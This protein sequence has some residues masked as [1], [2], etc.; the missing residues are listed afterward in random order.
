MPRA[1]H[2]ASRL[3]SEPEWVQQLLTLPEPSRILEVVAGRARAESGITAR[4]LGALL[5]VRDEVI[6]KHAQNKEI[7]R[8]DSEALK[9]SE[10]SALG[11]VAGYLPRILNWKSVADF[12]QELGIHRNHVESIV[13]Q[14]EKKEALR[15]SLD[16]KLYISPAGEQFVLEKKQFLDSLEVHESLADFGRRLRVKLNHLTAFFS[17]RGIALDAD[18]HGRARLTNEQ[19]EM[20]VTWRDTVLERRKHDDMI[21]DGQ[22][23]RSI[24][25]LAEDKAK[26]FAPQGTSRYNKIKGRELGSFRHYARAG[27]FQNKTDRGTYIPE[28]KAIV[29]FSSVTIAE[30]ARLV[31]VPVT[32]LKRWTRHNPSLLAPPLSGRRS[33][34][35]SI[36]ILL[37]HARHAY[38][39]EPVLAASDTIPTILASSAISRVGQEMGASFSR[40]CR[41]LPLPE[42]SEA[43]LRPRVG[44]IPRALSH[45]VTSLLHG[46]PLELDTRVLSPGVV[47]A[48]TANANRINLSS[49]ELLALALS[50]AVAKTCTGLPLEISAPLYLNV[51]RLGS[52]SSANFEKQLVVPAGHLAEIVSEWSDR[53]KIPLKTVFSLARVDEI[54]QS[55]L[56]KQG[57][58]VTGAVA[59]RLISFSRMSAAEF[60]KETSVSEQRFR[61]VIKHKAA[62][63][64]VGWSDL[65]RALPI[66][67]RSVKSLLVKDGAL[68]VS[69]VDTLKEVLAMSG[70]DFLS[71]LGWDS[72]LYSAAAMRRLVDQVS[73]ARSVAPERLYSFL[74]AFFG[75][76]LAIPRSHPELLK[77]ASKGPAIFP[78]KAGLLLAMIG[79]TK[80]RVHT[81]GVSTFTP[82]PGDILANMSLKDFGPILSVHTQDGGRIARVALVGSKA[83]LQFRV[84]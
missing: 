59:R 14:A 62:E 82:E 52:V 79:G 8:P 49:E 46:E 66:D 25:R 75:K 35:I 34:G 36:P 6:K 38:D 12:A 23:H 21:I 39:T 16:Q 78:V 37:D 44:M 17:S 19:K 51:I 71:S 41:L 54:D 67:G 55:K 81:Y 58:L 47:S 53:E 20:F 48:A 13:S 63:L 64:G 3:R 31:G 32:T 15:I 72:P 29:L 9:I 65:T 74:T 56:K 10:R 1:L 50:P 60:Q 5:K 22:P 43:L 73:V 76:S 7:V 27:G 57:G 80:G 26:L 83:S 28:E 70:M 30:A 84:P 33:R 40:V 24:V 61:S 68:A 4:E 18:I 11:I 2:L 77:Q 42:T 69:S 45:Q